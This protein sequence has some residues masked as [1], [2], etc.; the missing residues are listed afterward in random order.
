[1]NERNSPVTEAELHAYVDGQLP[2]DEQE[3]VAAL[4]RDD[5][6][7]AALAGEWRRQN[8]GIR[9]LFSGYARTKAEDAALIQT[10]GKGRRVFVAAPS[11][12]PFSRLSRSEGRAV[13]AVRTFLAL[14]SRREPSPRACRSRRMPPISSM[15]AR[16]GIRWKSF[17][18]RRRI[19][20][21]GSASG[22]IWTRLISRTWP[23]STSGSSVGVF[24]R[25]T[26]RRAHCSCMRT[27][28]Q[29]PVGHPWAQP[30]KSRHEFPLRVE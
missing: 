30:G 9:L 15:Q 1:M 18:I 21:H 6:E 19:L 7:Q 2:D 4:L 14:G 20:R 22:S 8:E 25:S 13:L 28:R 12:P 11:Q 17:P 10:A 24:C 26:A 5:P 29:A 16:S 3:R 23:R 27:G